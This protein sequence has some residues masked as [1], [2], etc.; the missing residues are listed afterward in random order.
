MTYRAFYGLTLNPFNKDIQADHIY[1]SQDYKQFSSR[2]E[3]FK[4]VRGF[5]LVYGEPGSG[6]TTSLR[7]FTAKLNPQLFRV[8]YLPLSSVTVMDFYR[9]LAVGLGLE[10]RFRKVDLFHQVQ[11]YIVNAYHQRNMATFVIID[12]AQFVHNAI[13]N[14]L[15]LLFN[16]QMDSKNYAM[17]C[18][19]G[20]PP[21]LN[22]LALQINEPL[23][24]RIIVSYGF[25]GLAKDEIGPYLS[26]LLQVAGVT[27]P[28]FTP[29]AVEAMAASSPMASPER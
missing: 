18:L 19:S 27:E 14:D 9:H 23:R 8:V 15:R 12:E 16:F 26:S 2:M 29:D 5:A 20:Q 28:L 24:Q 3:Y 17:V 6:K 13:L 10:P 21:F 7:A 11:D 4:T 22:Q 25:K 1:Q